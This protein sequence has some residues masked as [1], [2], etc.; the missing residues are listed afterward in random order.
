MV[1]RLVG[2]LFGEFRII[3]KS[4]FMKFGDFIF[5]V[6]DGSLRDFFDI[7]IFILVGEGFFGGYWFY[8]FIFR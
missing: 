5:W 2:S 7:C 3:Y 8:F 6:F 1:W 4:L